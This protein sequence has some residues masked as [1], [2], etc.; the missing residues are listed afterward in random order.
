MA[1]TKHVA[2]DAT[3]RVV[4]P[5][6]EYEFKG[7]TPTAF[8]YIDGKM[9]VGCS[10]GNVYTMTADV[11]DDGTQP[12]YEIQP[13]ILEL[14]FSQATANEIFISADSE[15]AFGYDLNLYRNGSSTALLTPSITGADAPTR[16]TVNFDFK[17]LQWKIDN[18]SITKPL[19]MTGLNLRITP[20]EI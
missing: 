1:H 4:Y 10:D 13:G 20:Q 15:A 9:H 8:N 2:K 12:D 5:W 18:L 7:L 16:E 6:T 19:K 14:D 17:S 11:N 3:G